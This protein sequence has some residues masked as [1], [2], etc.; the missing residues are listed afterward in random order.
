MIATPPS[1]ATL[2]P[3]TAVVC[4]IEDATEVVI[5]IP[6]FVVKLISLP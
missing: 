2:P 1:S 6:G 3:L 4:S 5:A